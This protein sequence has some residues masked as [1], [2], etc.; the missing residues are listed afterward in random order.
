[1]TAADLRTP[2]HQGIQILQI[3]CRETRPRQT[4]L[5]IKLHQSIV[6]VSLKYISSVLSQCMP[7]FM[8][9]NEIK[10]RCN[11]DQVFQRVIASIQ[12]NK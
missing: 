11:K 8:T 1:M 9:T 10:K 3:A 12:T 2:L 6:T 4:P 5:K 7:R